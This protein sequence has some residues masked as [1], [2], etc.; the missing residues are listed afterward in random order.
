MKTNI[1]YKLSLESRLNLA[2]RENNKN[3]VKKTYQNSIDDFFNKNLL[4]NCLRDRISDILNKYKDGGALNSKLN[5][6]LVKIIIVRDGK[7]IY[8]VILKYNISELKSSAV[9]LDL[10]KSFKRTFYKQLSEK[11]IKIYNISGVIVNIL[12]E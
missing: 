7:P 8:P 11:K 4:N 9:G 5:K 2:L 6:I 10:R 1:I 12:Y 3:K